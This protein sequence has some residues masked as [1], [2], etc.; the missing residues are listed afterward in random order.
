M[1]L[2]GGPSGDAVLGADVLKKMQR[3]RY[4]NMDGMRRGDFFFRGRATWKPPRQTFKLHAHK[5]NAQKQRAGGHRKQNCVVV[6]SSKSGQQ[7]NWTSD[8]ADPPS[9]IY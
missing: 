6:I 5:E 4:G 9:H 3:G 1:G 7:Q 2:L 8:G